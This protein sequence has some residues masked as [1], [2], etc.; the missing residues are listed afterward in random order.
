[1][2]MTFKKP[3]RLGF[4]PHNQELFERI[5]LQAKVKVGVRSRIKGSGFAQ[6]PETKTG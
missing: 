4:L 2:S 1:M 3:N 5:S 6:P